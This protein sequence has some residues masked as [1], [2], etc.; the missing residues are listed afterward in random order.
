MKRN[1]FTEH[2]THTHIDRPGKKNI[3]TEGRKFLV[4]CTRLLNIACRCIYVRRAR[5]VLCGGFTYKTDSATRRRNSRRA[6]SGISIIIVIRSLIH[7]R[8]S[9]S[10]IQAR[11]FSARLFSLL[12]LI[13]SELRHEPPPPPRAFGPATTS[14]AERNS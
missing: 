10:R 8:V 4:S 1:R 11:T 14:F 6:A 7:W 2:I 3:C 12:R 13:L 5:L 9:L